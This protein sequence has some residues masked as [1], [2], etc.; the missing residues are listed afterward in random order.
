MEDSPTGDKSREVA[1]VEDQLAQKE[2]QTQ[3]ALPTR[4]KVFICYS[5]KDKKEYDQL[6][7]NLK[8]LER[9]LSVDIWS[10]KKIVPGKLWK[11]E[12][13]K[14]LATAKVG[15]LLVSI[16]FLASDFITQYELPDLLAAAE[17]NNVTILVFLVGSCL[18]KESK[19]ALFQAVGNPSK[20]LRSIPGRDAKDQALVEL[21]RAI[22]VAAKKA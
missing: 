1:V 6:E 13:E 19:L 10:D 21:A 20:P 16:D 11:E 18:Y 22:I 17:T 15:V 8:V 14:A 4:S 3:F 5:H 12:I 2:A 9:D 7:K